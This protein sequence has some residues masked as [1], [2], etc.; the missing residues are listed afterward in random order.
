MREMD[1]SLPL[2]SP[3]DAGTENRSTMQRRL[4][5]T[6]LSRD[7]RAVP[8]P[9]AVGNRPP[10]VFRPRSCLLSCEL[11]VSVPVFPLG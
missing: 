2:P 10:G 6:A 4:E 3:P 5:L 9:L 1:S 11:L 7:G 8:L